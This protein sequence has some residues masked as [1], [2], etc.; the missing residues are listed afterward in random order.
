[1]YVFVPNTSFSGE[2]QELCLRY[3]SATRGP[4][5]P[6]CAWLW[7]IVVLDS[8][9]IFRGC[10][11]RTA[12]RCGGGTAWVRSNFRTRGMICCCCYYFVFV[13][14]CYWLSL[15]MDR[16]LQRSLSLALSESFLRCSTVSFSFSFFL[17]LLIGT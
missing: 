11:Y 10:L 16:R 7:F 14:F 8:F 2:S 12:S 3:L 17:C 4:A 5:A 9:G 15:P 13:L 1:M 6:L